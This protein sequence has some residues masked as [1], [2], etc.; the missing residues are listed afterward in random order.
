MQSSATAIDVTDLSK[1]Y[2]EGLVFR[3]IHNALSH[4]SLSVK[5][6]E[7]FGLLG[8]NGAGK[9]TL[10]KVLLGILHPNQGKATVLDLPAGSKS[11]R[12]KIGY[13]PENL[14]F[15]RHHTGRSALYFYGRLSE[16][17]DSK[18]HARENELWRLVGLSGRE[19]EPVR[20]YSKGMR[21]RLGLAQAMLHDPDLM[22]FDEPTDGLD[23]MG[24]QEIRN[25]LDQLKDRG[26]TVF[27]NSHILQEVE[28]VC[29]RVAILAL[30]KLR[31]IGTI[32]E[33]I[34][35][36]PHA[37]K[38]TVTIEAIGTFEWIKE[39]T[40]DCEV[41]DFSTVLDGIDSAVAVQRFAVDATVQA[42]VDRVVDRLRDS[43]I[44]IYRMQRFRPSLEQVFM[45]IVSA[46]TTPA[47]TTN[48]FTT[49]TPLKSTQ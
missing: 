26:K 32:D 29:D 11:A 44:S 23:P 5:R 25:V 47:I 33:L 17:N 14:V 8:P 38:A 4:V 2:R 45:G 28:L 27:L 24:R 43:S 31:G 20:R 34:E 12:R 13:L 49:Q 9:T 15:P 46:S 16:M 41:R 37:S 30:G 21:Q 36:H 3:K 40:R 35:N 10:I 48:T 39:A 19:H 22:V 18:I 6:G 7:V 1:T 42:N